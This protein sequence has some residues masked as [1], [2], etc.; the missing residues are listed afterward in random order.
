MIKIAIDAGHGLY[1]A[2]KRC[3]KELNEK[4]TRE[5]IINNAVAKKVVDLLKNYDCEVIRTDDI[6][7]I[8]DV[9]LESRCK[10][11]N[12]FGADV[13]ISIHHNSTS[14]TTDNATGVE[15]YC[16]KNP[17]KNTI[18]FRDTIYKEV[19]K[20]NNNKGNRADGTREENFYVLKH[21][22]MSAVLVENGFMNNKKDVDL[23][24]SDDY[25]SKTAA[26]IVNALVKFLNLKNKDTV[27]AKNKTTLKQTSNSTINISLNLL[28]NNVQ[29]NQVKTIQILLN[30]KIKANLAVDGVFGSK[31]Y[32]AVSK[33]QSN[34]K[35]KVDGIVG[36][37]TWNVLLK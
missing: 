37:E 6:M 8:T 27:V 31:T 26:G 28:K 23:I 4:E 36:I 32:A 18:D 14:N 9:S 35:I 30:Y 12:D 34:K 24:L 29:S 33:F 10:K 11:A 5:W 19:I 2:G 22:K 3:A 20:Q 16:C 15:V 17:P 13:F 7:G 25:Q 21:T 1:T